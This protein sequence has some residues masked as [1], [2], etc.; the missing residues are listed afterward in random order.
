MKLFIYISNYNFIGGVERFVENYCKRMNKHYDVTLLFDNCQHN[1]LLLEMSNYCNIEKFDKTKS[2]TSDYFICST[3]WGQSP[4]E[5]INAKK[6]VQIIHA[7]Y[8]HVIANWNFSYI[9]HRN[10]THHVC[11][12]E[13]VAKSFEIAT[14]YK[15]DAIIYNLL[16]N[17]QKL[18]KKSK[19]KVLSLITVSRLSGEK[20]FDRMLKFAKMLEVNKIDFIWDVYGNID[21]DY[22]NKIV[23]SFANTKVKFKGVIRNPM[24]II[25]Q[26]D[27]LVQLSDTEGFAYSVYEALQCKT[28]CIITPFASGNEQITDGVNGYI[29]PFDLKNIDFCRI[30][31][32]IPVVTDFQEI[33][34]EQAW[35]DFL[36]YGKG[37]KNNSKSIKRVQR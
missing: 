37:K 20:G 25:N 11:V 17:T 28:P 5:N 7:D 27:Y 31:N 1:E 34:S 2:Y 16:D 19:N 30:I 8:R 23:K 32:N 22:N 26:A 6:V 13:L 18:P 35:I 14:P 24:P 29:V 3:A 12:G 9:K 36:E 21:N 15:C 10:T 33:G 4:Y